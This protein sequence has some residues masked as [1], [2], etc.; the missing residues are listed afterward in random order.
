MNH[1]KN[2]LIMLLIREKKTRLNILSQI[3]AKV[4]EFQLFFNL[5]VIK[6]VVRLMCDTDA[7]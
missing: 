6:D 2:L 3:V 1:K 4:N 5:L 7:V